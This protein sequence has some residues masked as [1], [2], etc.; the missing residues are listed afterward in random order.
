[1]CC[2]GVRMDCGGLIGQWWQFQLRPLIGAGGSTCR[3]LPES[4]G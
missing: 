1:M 2:R 4:R 3:G